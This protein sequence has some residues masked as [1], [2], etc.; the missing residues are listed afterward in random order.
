MEMH[1]S[2]DLYVFMGPESCFSHN[3][4]WFLNFMY[5][6][7]LCWVL[8]AAGSPSLVASGGGCSLLQC[9]ASHWGG[10][11]CY[12]AQ[13]L[14]HTGFDCCGVWAQQLHLEAL[15]ALQHVESSQ[16]RNRT[17]VPCIGRLILNHWITRDVLITSFF[18]L[19]CQNNV[20]SMVQMVYIC[21]SRKVLLILVIHSC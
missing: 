14:E 18:F 12:G 3:R 16:T 2:R 21:V 5:L 7:W 8:T 19:D 1:P 10:F 13:A 11:S 17:C 15:V 20:E 6:F 9:M 4:I